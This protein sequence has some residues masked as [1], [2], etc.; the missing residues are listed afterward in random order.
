MPP[1]AAPSGA[2]GA[3]LVDTGGRDTGGVA[4]AARALLA[5]TATVTDIAD[6]RARIGSSLTAVD[7]TQLTRVELGFAL[8]LAVAAGGLVSALGLAER[9]RSTAI[10]GALG[11]TPRQLRAFVLGETSLVTVGGIA[12][13]ALGGWLRAR[14]RCGWRVRRRPAPRPADAPG[15]L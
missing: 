14:G 5:P 3:F 7:L 4:A 10:T 9:R 15:R 13:G 6:V 11:A 1:S 12:L 2:V 8:A